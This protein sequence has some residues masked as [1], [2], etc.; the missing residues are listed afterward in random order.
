MH[1]NFDTRPPMPVDAY[2]HTVQSVNVGYQLFLALSHS[3]LRSLAK[4][5]LQLLVVGAGGGAEIEAFLPPNPGWRLTGVDPSQ[6]MLALARGRTERSGVADR[7]CLV[8]GAVDDLPAD[9]VFDAATCL[10]V[11]HFLADDD[12]RALLRGIALR[13]RLGA[14]VLV[15]S[16]TRVSVDEALRA[17]VLGTWQQYGQLAGMQAERMAAT[18][19]ELTRQQAL[20]TAESDYVRLF[21]EAG[22]AHV[23]QLLSVFNGGLVAWL[24]R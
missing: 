16:A 24:L 18:I 17:D 15:A 19:A 7:V 2:A 23:A 4:Q 21:H 12:K 10:F 5:E 20:A 11:L 1:V 6:D 8:R 9:A 14:P 3:C 13:V 22:F